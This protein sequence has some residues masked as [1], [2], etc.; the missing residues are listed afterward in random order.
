[1]PTKTVRERKPKVGQKL[2]W[3]DPCEF[4]RREDKD[5]I[6][7]QQTQYPGELRVAKVVKAPTGNKYAWSVEMTHNAKPTM[8]GATSNIPSRCSMFWLHIDD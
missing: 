6:T 8:S 5:F 4:T 2:R 7:H 1:M 3:K